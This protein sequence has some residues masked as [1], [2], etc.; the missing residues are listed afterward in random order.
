VSHDS[1]R[2]RKPTR[3][4]I[5]A[6]MLSRQYL[7]HKHSIHQDP[8]IYVE[9]KEGEEKAVE[10]IIVYWSI[11]F[12]LLHVQSQ[13]NFIAGIQYDYLSFTGTALSK[14]YKH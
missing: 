11:K 12:M 13:N 8:P 14:S 4:D 9:N 3:P 5:I 6:N 7:P 2:K 10:D 1:L